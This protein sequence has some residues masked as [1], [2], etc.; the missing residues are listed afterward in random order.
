M[1]LHLFFFD[2]RLDDL[3]FLGLSS[4]PYLLSVLWNRHKQL[5]MNLI[6]LR[7]HIN[8]LCQWWKHVEQFADLVLVIH[9]SIQIVCT[10]LCEA[11]SYF[12][13]LVICHYFSYCF[14]SV[15]LAHPFLL[16]YHL[17]IQLQMLILI[18]QLLNL[19]TKLIILFLQIIAEGVLFSCSL[20]HSI[21]LLL[22]VHIGWYFL[23]VF[24]LPFAPFL[25]VIGVDQLYLW[26]LVPLEFIYIILL[27]FLFAHF[28]THLKLFRQLFVFIS[29]LLKVFFIFVD[30]FGRFVHSDLILS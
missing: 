17:C 18:L 27:L 9:I 5:L 22:E 7:R 23:L 15:C 19:R 24:E 8:G 28:N 4:W 26:L 11:L 2:F 25:L 16:L 3:F 12:M 1:K 10:I 21:N 20:H 14:V 29:R 13:N 6:K 30:P